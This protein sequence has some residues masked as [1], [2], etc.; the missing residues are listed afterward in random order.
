MSDAFLAAERL[1]HEAGLPPDEPV[2]TAQVVQSLYPGACVRVPRLTVQ[3]IREYL[4]RH[5]KW[6]PP[7]LVTCHDRRLCGGVIA[8]YG[9]G[10]LFVDE[11]DGQDEQE[12]TLAH[13]AFHFLADHFYPRHDLLHRFG[14]TI[15]PVLDGERPA[16]STEKFAAVVGRV[17]LDLQAHLLDRDR[18]SSFIVGRE[19]D[20]DLFACELLAPRAALIAC[21]P[22]LQIGEEASLRVQN[23]VLQEFHL[24]ET[25]AETWARHFVSATGQRAPRPTIFDVGCRTFRI[26]SE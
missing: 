21:F 5:A 19:Q 10:I 8:C 17:R 12:L 26:R 20:A 18:P 25:Q 11:D 3:R 16:T 22:R 4:D 23:W 24:P 6:A 13:E 9:R 15:L 14:E 2:R 7:G 1:R